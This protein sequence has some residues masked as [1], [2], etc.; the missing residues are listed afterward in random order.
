MGDC[1][2]VEL[3]IQIPPRMR[4][5]ATALRNRLG[6]LSFREVCAVQD[7]HCA[8][9]MAARLCAI[10]SSVGDAETSIIAARARAPGWMNTNLRNRC[11]SRSNTFSFRQLPT[12]LRAAAKGGVRGAIEG[13]PGDARGDSRA[14]ATAQPARDGITNGGQTYCS[15]RPLSSTIK[16]SFE[17]VASYAIRAESGLNTSIAAS[18]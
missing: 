17:P 15:G 1:P 14:A 10:G 13:V 4:W 2:I 9:D 11:P 6:E 3:T 16:N 5:L 8:N 12:T 7:I 18:P